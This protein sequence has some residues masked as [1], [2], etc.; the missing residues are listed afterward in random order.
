[1]RP[2][3]TYYG[4]KWYAARKYPAPALDTIVEPFAGAAGYSV[5]F[6]APRVVLVD[7]DPNIT[8]TWKYL[9]NV[10]EDE[11]RGLPDIDPYTQTVDD[12]NVSPEAKRIIGWWLNKGTATPCKTPAAW[13]KKE[14]Y[15]SQFWGPRVRERIASQ[16]QDIRHW[17]VIEGGFED[18]PDIE[19]TWFVDPPYQTMGKYYRFN[20]VDYTRLGEWCRTLRGQVI[21]CEGAGA[22][23]LPFV[24]AFDFKA[25]TRKGGTGAVTKEVVWYGG[26]EVGS[27][28]A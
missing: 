5:R 16:L 28:A 22:D 10:S 19:A 26:Q 25:T 7:K 8:E 13:M 17:Q 2:F 15:R 27:D 4:G 18:A 14:E 23:W 1:M 3:F 6:N 12:L 9:I 24:P 11:I 20:K 21:V